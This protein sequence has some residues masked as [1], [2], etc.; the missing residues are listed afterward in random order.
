MGNNFCFF[1]DASLTNSEQTGLKQE[2]KNKLQTSDKICTTTNFF[3]CHL[4]NDVL[5]I[6]LYIPCINCSPQ[7]T[8]LHIYSS[9]FRARYYYE[10]Y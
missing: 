10:Y 1:Y 8:D 2:K 4:L 7:N 3:L 5:I 9:V 6:V